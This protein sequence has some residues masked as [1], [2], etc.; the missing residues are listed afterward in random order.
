MSHPVD[1]IFAETRR[2]L[3]EAAIEIFMEEGY[4]A[5][6]DRIATRAGVA[7]QTLYNHYPAKEAL[8][9]EAIRAGVQSVLVTLESRSGDLRTNLVR[10]ANAYRSKVLCPIGSAIFRTIVAEAPRFPEL[11]KSFF[12]SGPRETTEQLARFLEDAMTRGE[13]RVEDPLFAAEMLTAMLSNYDRL[14]ALMN[15]ETDTLTDPA[16]VERVVDCFL[17]AF[18]PE[19]T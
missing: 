9:A 12:A 5:S 11:A 1:S 13:L 6:I 18:A 10:F 17:R 4:R 14:R 19:R 8:F 2:R 7:R 3:L 16:K 15:L